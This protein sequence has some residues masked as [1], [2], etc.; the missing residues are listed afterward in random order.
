MRGKVFLDEFGYDYKGI[1]P[2]YAGKRAR[3]GAAVEA[4]QDH[5]RVCGEKQ[6]ARQRSMRPGGSPPRMRGKAALFFCPRLLLR[7]TPAYA[8][9]RTA[10]RVTRPGGWDHPRVCGEKSSPR[11]RGEQGIG[12]PPR[13]RGKAA[14]LLPSPPLPG[15]TPAYA[16]KSAHTSRS[17]HNSGDHPRVCGEKAR[18]CPAPPPRRG[19]PPR[20]RGKGQVIFQLVTLTGITP[21]YAGKSAKEIAPLSV[22]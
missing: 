13:M 18:P 4:L 15:I 7:I 2:A 22:G 1:T 11:I 16:G 9:K 20:M 17:A 6:M 19:S 21:A 14:M 12:S 8:G 3:V 5:P 10:A